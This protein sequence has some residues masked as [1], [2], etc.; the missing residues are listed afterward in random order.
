[1][2]VAE[3]TGDIRDHV[4]GEAQDHPLGGRPLCHSARAAP[5]GVLLASAPARTDERT[6][7]DGV[8]VVIMT[9]NRV[10]ELL[11]TL[12]RLTAL[13]EAP[14]IVVADNG[15]TDGTVERVQA[16]FPDVDVIALPDNLGVEARNVAVR[17]ARTP[18]IA[19]NDDDSWWAPGALARVNELFEGHPRLGAVTAH[20]VAEPSGEDDPTSLVMRHSPVSGDGSVPGIPVLGFLACATAVRRSAFLEVGG[21]EERLHFVGEE[22][23]LATD[24]VSAG[25]RVQ[26][27][28]ELV[29]RHQ[30]ST[31]RDSDWRL[32][33]GIRNTL[34]YLW[35][36]R[37]AR[38]A[39]RRSLHLLRHAPPR[40]SLP[41]VAEAVRRGRWVLSERRVVP[42][43]VERDLRRL[44]PEQERSSARQY[45]G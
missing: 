36:R 17:R 9:R 18:Y 30:A 42:P 1:M 6:D 38:S 44:D 20:I 29:V 31:S 39:I 23:L 2:H 4:R 35:L 34:W 12:K 14:P 40:A 37:P 32:R 27:V 5:G 8:T 15:S 41:A 19:F 13:P 21:F 26:Y 28:P 33:R 22:E 16:S 11:A 3:L 24:L 10:D 43:E 7:V 45:A 25:W